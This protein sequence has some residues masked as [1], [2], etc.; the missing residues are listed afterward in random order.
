MTFAD[1]ERQGGDRKTRK[2]A[3]LEQM[4]SVAPWAD[5]VALVEPHRPKA[6]GRGRQPWL[7]ETLLRMH[8]AQCWLGLSDEGME[9]ACY[10]SC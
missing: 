8:L 2:A 3:F 10:D 9:D 4:D 6:G 1:A 5:L 7:T